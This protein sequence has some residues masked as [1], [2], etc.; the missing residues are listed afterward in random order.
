[1]LPSAATERTRGGAINPIVRPA[2][3]LDIKM[4]VSSLYANQKLVRLGTFEP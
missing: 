2:R 4:S 3:R 1:V